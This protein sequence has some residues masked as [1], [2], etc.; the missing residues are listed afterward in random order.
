MRK[1]RDVLR[2]FA[3]GMSKRDRRQ[4]IARPSL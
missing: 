2:L 4:P 3:A 1:L